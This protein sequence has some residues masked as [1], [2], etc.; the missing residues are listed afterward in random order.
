MITFEPT[1]RES[2]VHD[3]IFKM[4]KIKHSTYFSSWLIVWVLGRVVHQSQLTLDSLKLS[5]SKGYHIQLHTCMEGS[6]GRCYTVYT[7]KPN[8]E[9]D[10]PRNRYGY[11][12]TGHTIGTIHTY[13]K[14]EQSLKKTQEIAKHL[15]TMQQH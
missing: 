10:L 11:G 12:H 1:H 7:R 2:L 4:L 13:W 6:L 15:I 9:A 8:Q 14:P 5:R 3:A